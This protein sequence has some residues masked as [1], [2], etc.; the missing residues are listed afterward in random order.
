MQ[1]SNKYKF[2]ISRNL[3]LI[4]EHVNGTV[5]SGVCCVHTS[6][7]HLAVH[8]IIRR[9]DQHRFKRVINTCLMYR[10]L[11]VYDASVNVRTHLKMC[12]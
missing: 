12:A 10:L 9:P 6:F 3:F 4:I 7:Q 5:Q 2:Q 11:G 1:C 8:L